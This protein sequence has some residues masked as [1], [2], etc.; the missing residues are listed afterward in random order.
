MIVPGTAKAPTQARDVPIAGFRGIL[1]NCVK[2]GT[3]T[4][5]RRRPRAG[6]TGAG[7]HADGGVAEDARA[8]LRGAGRRLGSVRL[9]QGL[10]GGQGSGR[11]DPSGRTTGRAG[12]RWRSWAAGGRCPAPPRRR[13]CRR[14]PW[15][16]PPVPSPRPV[17]HRIKPSLPIPRMAPLAAPGMMTGSELPDYDPAARGRASTSPAVKDH[18]AADAEQAGQDARR[19][20]EQDRQQVAAPHQRPR[21]RSSRR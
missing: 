1:A 9:R 7:H 13:C 18:A 17:G 3:M 12:Q 10:L 5:S 21:R 6:R 14:P 20:S 15:P 16:V 11:S 19:H 4:P 8:A 2:P